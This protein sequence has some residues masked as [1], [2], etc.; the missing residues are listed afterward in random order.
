MWRQIRSNNE[1][2]DDDGFVENYDADDWHDCQ[3]YCY[4]TNNRDSSAAK[5][6]KLVSVQLDPDAM[7]AVDW[8]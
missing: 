2:N 7:A 3:Q 5:N 8:R 1:D 4:E 6:D